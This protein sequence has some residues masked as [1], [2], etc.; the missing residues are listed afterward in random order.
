MLKHVPISQFAP[1]AARS[2]GDVLD[3]KHRESSRPITLA[4]KDE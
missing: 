4:E 1:F 2:Q 3:V